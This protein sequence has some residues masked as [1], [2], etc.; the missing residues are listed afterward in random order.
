LSFEIRILNFK[1]IGVIG[2]EPIRQ[3]SQRIDNKELTE[4]TNDSLCASLCKPLQKPAENAV[5]DSAEI[6]NITSDLHRIIT[7]W[8]K[9]SEAAKD[10]IIKF[11][12]KELK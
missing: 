8:P 1:A 5:I 11:I 9:L 6:Q 3:N 2:F 10:N 4:N 7:A 12:D